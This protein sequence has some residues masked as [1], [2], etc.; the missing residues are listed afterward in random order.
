MDIDFR[1]VFRTFQGIVQAA[2]AWLAGRAAHGTHGHI[3]D[4][5]ASF[6]CFWVCVDAVSA[7]VMCMQMNRQIDGIFQFADQT[8][9]RLRFQKASHIL[10]CDD[11]CTQW[12]KLFGHL[13]VVLDG[14]F[15]L[16]R[17]IDIASVAD[18]CFS[19]L[20]IVAHIL[21]ALFHLFRPV[22]TVEDTENIDSVFSGKS[23]ELF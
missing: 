4:V 18:G 15:C 22:Q 8:V 2:D 17:I 1:R 9:S 6:D 20:I 10:D 21:D 13:F 23:D 12:F 19:N 5:Y 14:V 11:V 3:Y 7:C 16:C